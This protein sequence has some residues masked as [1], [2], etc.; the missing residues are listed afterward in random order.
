MQ[1]VDIVEFFT[2]TSSL[3]SQAISIP[4]TSNNVSIGLSAR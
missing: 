3:T 2:S 4:T 1:V